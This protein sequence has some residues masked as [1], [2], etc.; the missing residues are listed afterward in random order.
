[1]TAILKKEIQ[2]FFSSPVGYLVIGVFLTVCGLFLFVF[3]GTY[4]ILDNGF[5]DLSP[6]FNLA[7]WIFI[8]LIPAITM[9]SFSEE[10]KQGT[11]E[12]LLTKPIGLWNLVW[13]KFL[14]VFLLIIIALLPSILYVLTIYQLG[15]PVGNFDAGATLGS[16]FG[17]LLL[18]SCYTAIGLFASSLSKS[19]ITA[20]I[21]AVFLC[22]ISFFAFEGLAGYELFKDSAYGMEYLGISYHYKSMSRG[23]LDTRDLIYFLSLVILFLTLTY[24]KIATNKNKI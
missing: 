21:L 14:G 15:N 11:M 3:S 6:F 16:Y 10:K 9:K 1:M 2:S 5:A 7:P 17:L 13:G 8:F 4:N 23:V 18:A 20:F 12:L 22:F 24:F 19:Q